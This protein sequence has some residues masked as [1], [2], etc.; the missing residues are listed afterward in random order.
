[1]R[2]KALQ[3]TIRWAAERSQLI[4]ETAPRMRCIFCKENSDHSASVE[5]IVPESLGNKEHVLPPG[6]VCDG[7]NNYLARE[8]EK[9]FLASQYGEYSRFQMGIVNK[10]GRIPS[11]KGWHPRSG[12]AVKLSP[13]ESGGLD[14]FPQAERDGARWVES[15]LTHRH[16]TLV[17]PASESP[18][19]D[20]VT[21]RFIGKIAIEVLAQR[22]I[23]LPGWNDEVVGNP[24]LDGLRRHVRRGAQEFGWPV[25]I[26]RIYPAEFLFTDEAGNS[27]ELLHEWDIMQTGNGEYLVVVAILGLEYAINLGSPEVEG[28]RQWLAHNG[29]RSPLRS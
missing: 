22:C 2:I 20:A 10:R 6:W 14:V 27:Y 5:H 1:M 28:Y 4:R 29:N 26:R 15:I 18:E 16:G 24:G 3:L 23:S 13:S 21:S 7:C 19:S 25:H 8:V 9:P 11:A 17:V 12:V